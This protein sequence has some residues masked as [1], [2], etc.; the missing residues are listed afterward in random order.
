MLTNEIKL[1]SSSENRCEI[2][3]T[4]YHEDEVLDMPGTRRH[5]NG[6]AGAVQKR[7]RL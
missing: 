5:D 2:T 6:N 7:W 4:D 1:T 3:H